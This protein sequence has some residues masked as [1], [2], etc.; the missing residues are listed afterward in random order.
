MTSTLL[1]TGQTTSINQARALNKSVL[2]R[3]E[4]ERIKYL[5]YCQNFE[6]FGNQKTA[7]NHLQRTLGG[8][9]MSLESAC[10]S[11]DQSFGR[12]KKVSWVSKLRKRLDSIQDSGGFEEVEGPGGGDGGIKK[13]IR[14]RKLLIKKVIK[15]MMYKGVKVSLEVYNIK[16]CKLSDEEYARKVNEMLSV[17]KSRAA[18]NRISVQS[19]QCRAIQQEILQKKSFD[20][21]R[22]VEEGQEVA[23]NQT[24][25]S[26]LTKILQNQPNGF[27]SS[28]S[29]YR[30]AEA[31]FSSKAQQDY[32]H[33]DFGNNIPVFDLEIDS[34]KM[35]TKLKFPKPKLKPRLAFP[36]PRVAVLKRL[37]QKK[38]LLTGV[39]PKSDKP[40]SDHKNT[41]FGDINKDNG[42]VV[43]RAA[44]SAAGLGRL[45]VLQDFETK[46]TKLTHTFVTNQQQVLSVGNQEEGVLGFQR[47]PSQ[48]NYAI[49]EIYETST[50]ATT[51]ASESLKKASEKEKGTSKRRRS[52]KHLQPSVHHFKLK[53]K[54]VMRILS[55][56]Q[57]NLLKIK[58]TSRSQTKSSPQIS[59]DHLTTI[60]K[61]LRENFVLLSK[62]YSEVKSQHA[63]SLSIALALEAAIKAG[64]SSRAFVKSI[65]PV[66]KRRNLSVKEIRGGACYCM[67][68]KMLRNA[69]HRSESSSSEESSGE[70]V[71]RAGGESS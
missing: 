27:K 43:Q 65:K 2:K 3:S 17:E 49:H 22:M 14:K 69:V 25:H 33:H 41:N 60:K 34:G 16:K 36:V 35:P 57:A 5:H 26:P 37:K 23:Q 70:G 18:G 71:G 42:H 28:Q 6:K 4:N 59:E 68:K 53:L 47:P 21:A 13:T 62:H 67:V 1:V 11:S 61:R 20:E 56:F 29:Q 19:V 40:T 50:Q 24:Q 32:H 48:P 12:K 55:A 45:R 8:S 44:N 31:K 10:R 51:T 64:L 46:Y 9:G 38:E 7:H 30:Q 39:D 54:K 63:D 15:T 58:A 66:V 52:F